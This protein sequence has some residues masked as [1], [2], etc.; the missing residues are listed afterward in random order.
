MLCIYREH[1]QLSSSQNRNQTGT[2][3]SIPPSLPTVSL[4]AYYYCLFIIFAKCIQGNPVTYSPAAIR[5]FLSCFSGLLLHLKRSHIMQNSFYQSFLTIICV[6]SMSMDSPVEVSLSK[7]SDPYLTRPVGYLKSRTCIYAE[8]QKYQPA[9]NMSHTKQA[10]K[11][12][13]D[14]HRCHSS[15][16]Y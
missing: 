16:L 11:H 3:H 4:S 14:Q 2:L 1:A 13:P 15:L 10:R 6:S 12:R 5:Q 9:P 7:N 8:L